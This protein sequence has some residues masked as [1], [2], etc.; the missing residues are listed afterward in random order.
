MRFRTYLRFVLLLTIIALHYST[1][2]KASGHACTYCDWC[3][4]D[5]CCIIDYQ[6]GG[7]N[8]CALGSGFCV[9]YG[10]QCVQS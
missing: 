5:H 9:E 6:G 10:S 3:G 4:D 8:G 7:S 1:R 2:A